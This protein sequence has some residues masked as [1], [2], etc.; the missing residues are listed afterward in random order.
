MAMNRITVRRHTLVVLAV[1]LATVAI[2]CEEVIDDPAFRLWCGDN[3]CSWHTD[4]G[5]IRRAPTWHENDYGVE[6]LGAPTTLSQVATSVPDCIEFSMM[7][8]V[9][10]S[11]QVTLGIDFNNDG[12][13]DHEEPIPA[14]RWREVKSLV[15]APGVY[16]G[17]RFLIRKKGAGHAVVAL[18][19][20]QSSTLC[21][22]PPLELHDLP[23]G[24]T[25]AP[26]RNGADCRSGV[27][28]AAPVTFFGPR[29]GVCSECCTGADCTDHRAC[30]RRQKLEVSSAVILP[31]QCN[32]GD[33]QRAAG[34]EC[35]FNDDCVSGQCDTAKHWDE[36]CQ[37]DLP[38]AGGDGCVINFVRG[39]RCQ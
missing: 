38:S 4:E 24:S 37:P 8:D 28:C 5:S 23:L 21:T 20:A 25:C 19:R 26:E 15:R 27:C 31:F 34:A 39:G 36:P 35:L 22:T 14:V 33:G 18:V 6:L 1:G 30:E 9:D 10:A 17:I 11:A 3:L 13:V 16:S 12:A 2:G 7:A 29:G 32:P